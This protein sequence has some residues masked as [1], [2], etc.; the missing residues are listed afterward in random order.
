MNLRPVGHIAGNLA[1]VAILLSARIHAEDGN[2]V[3]VCWLTDEG[4]LYAERGS[5]P[6]ARAI[7]R[8]APELVIARYRQNDTL[9]WREI[10]NDLDMARADFAARSLREALCA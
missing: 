6:T 10:H 2:A 3:H 7:E 5:H 8:V 9:T 1:A 4:C